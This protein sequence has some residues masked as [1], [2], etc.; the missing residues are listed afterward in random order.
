MLSAAQFA[1][2][3]SVTG[4]PVTWEQAKPPQ[5][6]QQ[7][8]AIVQSLS[9]AP[10][11]IVNAYGI[12]ARSIQVA[13]GTVAPEKFDQFI[14][15]QGNRYTVDLVIEHRERG[16]GALISFTCYAKGK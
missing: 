7:V 10:E 1:S 8:R 16:T 5:A 14:D 2:L 3:L 13:A 6:T 12:D 11:N 15:G 9:R 4:E